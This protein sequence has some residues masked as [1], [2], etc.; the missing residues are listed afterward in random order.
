MGVLFGS[1][2]KKYQHSP[3]SHPFFI[4]LE[5][6]LLVE[7]NVSKYRPIFIMHNKNEQERVVLAK[8]WGMGV[9]LVVSIKIYKHSP[10]SH[11][12]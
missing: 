11:L 5:E 12:F 2:Y 7:A 1:L 6:M 10:H 4:Q 3:H 9:L 8:R